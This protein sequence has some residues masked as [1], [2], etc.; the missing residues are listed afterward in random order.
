MPAALLLLLCI[1]CNNLGKRKTAEAVMDK[2]EEKVGMVSSADSAAGENFHQIPSSQQR[3]NAGT[4][5]GSPA[6]AGSPDWDKK[7][8][9]T[10]DL[11]LEVKSFR[12]FTGRLRQ[13]IQRSGGY[14]A[15][16]Q[17]TQSLS[18]IENTVTIK[19]PVDKFDDFLSQLPSDSD[20]LVD[21]KRW[22]LRREGSL[23]SVIRRR[24]VWST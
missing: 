8:I 3:V 4:K 17:Q 23:I 7:I 5:K 2:D 16:E 13:M 19:V 14:M 9:K 10:A 12:T 20:R 22:T 24:I 11:N 15:Q 1:A 6:P 21:R 18:E